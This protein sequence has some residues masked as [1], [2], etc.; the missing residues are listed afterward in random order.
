MAC[1]CLDLS[2]KMWLYW[3]LGLNRQSMSG[4]LKHPKLDSTTA[5]HHKTSYHMRGSRKFSLWVGRADGSTKFKENDQNFLDLLVCKGLTRKKQNTK[6][7]LPFY[8][9]LSIFQGSEY[10]YNETCQHAVILATL[11]QHKKHLHF[12]MYISQ[13]NALKH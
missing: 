10:R 11:T 7:D 2:W 5:N 8:W 9:L 12:W 4:P 1:S 3:K 6:D 13:G